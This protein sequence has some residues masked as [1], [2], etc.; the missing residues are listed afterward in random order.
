LQKIDQHRSK[1]N[2]KLE[3]HPTPPPKKTT[4]RINNL[5]SVLVFTLCNNIIIC[6]KRLTL[7]ALRTCSGAIVFFSSRLHT[8]LDSEDRRLMNS[9]KC[10]CTVQL[11]EKPDY[12]LVNKYYLSVRLLETSVQDV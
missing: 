1:K 7:R 6:E 10:A 5:I 12:M 2:E 9:A 4:A 11:E 8:S 3:P